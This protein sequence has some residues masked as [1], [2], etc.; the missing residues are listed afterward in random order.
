V[1]KGVITSLIIYHWRRSYPL[2]CQLRARDLAVVRRWR[3]HR[4]R[5]GSTGVPALRLRV[6]AHVLH[7]APSRWRRRPALMPSVWLS[8]CMVRIYASMHGLHHQQQ[9]FLLMKLQQVLLLTQL[10]TPYIQR[11]IPWTSAEQSKRIFCILAPKLK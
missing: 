10:N 6:G 2:S 1:I 4:R 9:R 8:F 3:R 7:S 11:N 5:R